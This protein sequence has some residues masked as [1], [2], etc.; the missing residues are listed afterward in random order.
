MPLIA[1]SGDSAREIN[2]YLMHYAAG[3][4]PVILVDCA[5][6]ADPHRYYPALDVNAMA[7][8][9]VFEL[10]LLHKFRDV[11]R[12]VPVYA[13]RLKAGCV[14]VTTSD[15]LLNY[16]NDAENENIYRH[17]WELMK[18]LSLTRDVVVGVPRASAHYASAVRFCDDIR[19][20]QW[21]TPLPH[22][23]R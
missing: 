20:I 14:I 22:S 12:Q 17:A 9:Y 15:R 18:K 16:H 5:N 11:L 3:R 19:E 2:R 13:N 23:G 1:F 7:Q 10:E 6:A 4:V 21:D 8:I